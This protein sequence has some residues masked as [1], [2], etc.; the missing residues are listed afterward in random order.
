[1]RAS[2]DQPVYP[3]LDLFPYATTS[4]IYIAVAGASAVHKED[5][6]YFEAWIDRMIA[7][8][9]SFPDWNNEKE[10][11]EVL[12]QLTQARAIYEQLK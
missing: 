10:K 6:A 9:K 5:V 7:A 12:Q 1:L 2:N 8:A 3:V 11:S 4:P